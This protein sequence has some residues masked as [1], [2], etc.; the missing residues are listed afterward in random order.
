VV[1]ERPKRGMGIKVADKGRRDIVVRIVSNDVVEVVASLR[2]GVVDVDD[3]E[4]DRSVI[5]D[6]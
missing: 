3:A 6:V 5:E 4:S 2:S 1:R